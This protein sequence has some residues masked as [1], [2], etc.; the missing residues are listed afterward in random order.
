VSGQLSSP[1]D[2]FLQ[3]LSQM[4][5]VE[6]MLAFEVLPSLRSQVESES[7]A[8]A[9][10]HHLAQTHEH[11][12]RVETT[13]REL[14]AEPVSARSATGAAL[15]DEHGELAPKIVDSRLADLFHAGAAIRG[16][17]L[18]LAGYELLLELA[19]QLGLDGAE[20]L[21]AENLEDDSRAL[22]QVR[23][24]ARQ[25]RDELPGEI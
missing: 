16:E 8:G 25:L 7:L 6:R 10:E 15:S 17:H 4:L 11:V 23:A 2:L 3:L 20:K 9:L 5:W 18:E 24:L 14:G 22:D 13:F 12:A 1:R 21:L 19:G